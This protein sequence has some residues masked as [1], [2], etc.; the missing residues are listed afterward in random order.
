MRAEDFRTTQDDSQPELSQQPIEAERIVLRPL[1]N[2]DAELVARHAGDRRIAQMT[3]AVPFPMSLEA[4]EEYVARAL[5]TDRV[6]DIWVID[7]TPGGAAPFLGVISL[8]YLG[9]D[10]SEVDYWVAPTFWN[11]GYA[12]EALRAL[13]EAN[14]HDN[15]SVVASVF[16]DNPASA[17]VLTGAGF[18]CL[19]EAEAF[20]LARGKH[21]PTWTYLKTLEGDG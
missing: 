15:R 17:R 8:R 3:C 9:R 1:R 5:D 21:V 11:R 14:P 6:E 13:L 10:Q 2:S 20:S 19:G 12:S 16:Q 7:G 4:A 18:T